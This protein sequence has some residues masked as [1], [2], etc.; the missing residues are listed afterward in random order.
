MRPKLRLLFDIPYFF[1]KL[2]KLRFL[3]KESLC[4]DIRLAKIVQKVRKAKMNAGYL[5]PVVQW[6]LRSQG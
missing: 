1:K 3:L 5:L 6:L 4:G 2:V